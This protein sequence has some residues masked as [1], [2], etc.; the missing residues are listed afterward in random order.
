M[1]SYCKDM[2]KAMLKHK[3]DGENNSLLKVKYIN[4]D[5]WL[6]TFCFDM[7]NYSGKLFKLRLKLLLFVSQIQQSLK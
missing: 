4:V 1:R 7:F 5:K 2:M 3:G 6:E